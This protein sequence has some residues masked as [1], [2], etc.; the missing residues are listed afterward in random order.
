MTERVQ[1]FAEQAIER[2]LK[3]MNEGHD[4]LTDQI[5]NWLCERPQVED[6]ELME[7]VV[8]D[9][10]KTLASC[11]SYVL[12]KARGRAKSGFAAIHDD[13]VFGWVR[14][15]FTDD[16]IMAEYVDKKSSAKAKVKTVDAED[17]EELDEE[18]VVEDKQE[19]LKKKEIAKVE[20]QLQKEKQKAKENGF[21]DIFEFL[22]GQDDSTEGEEGK[23]DEENETDS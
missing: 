9:K 12:S 13:V 3:E 5:H 20:K 11:C 22:G 16:R 1:T 19:I 10:K 23:D 2:M 6:A 17:D 15:Y 21:M 7:G 4:E 8:K 18:V 14:E